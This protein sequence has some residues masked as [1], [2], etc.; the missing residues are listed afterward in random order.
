M[1]SLGPRPRRYIRGREQVQQ[2]REGGLC[3]SKLARFANSR[4]RA[5]P[6]AIAVAIVAIA[7]AIF[8]LGPV[9]LTI[10]SAA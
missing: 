9:I 5:S 6:A 8:A 7:V 1:V 10:T 4:S 3:V 2:G